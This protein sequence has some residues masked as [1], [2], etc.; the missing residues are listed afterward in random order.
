MKKKLF[1][2][3]IF[4]WGFF[5]K[6]LHIFAQEYPTDRLFIKNFKKARCLR[7]VEENV[8][9]LKTKREMTLEHELL[10]NNNIWNKIRTKLPLSNGEKKRLFELRENGFSSKTLNSKK[11]WVM[12]EKKFNELRSECK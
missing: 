3:N 1:Y 9:N 8:Q 12:K 10:L 2:F 11:L 5:L 6:T 4:F 7:I